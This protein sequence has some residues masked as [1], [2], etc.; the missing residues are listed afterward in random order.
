M[1]PTVIFILADSSSV[2]AIDK[3]VLMVKPRLKELIG[4]G[5]YFTRDGIGTFPTLVLIGELSPREDGGSKEL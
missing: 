2:T 1:D 3:S 4:S 5:K